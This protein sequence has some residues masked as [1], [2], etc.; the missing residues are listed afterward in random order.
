MM[1]TEKNWSDL[2]WE[3]RNQILLDAYREKM[4][5]VIPDPEELREKLAKLA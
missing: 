4:L 1:E 3:E 5:E 2:T